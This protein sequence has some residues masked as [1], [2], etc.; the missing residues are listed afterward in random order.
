ML[1]IKCD[2][3]IGLGVK[4]IEGFEGVYFIVGNN[5][6]RFKWYY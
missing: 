3:Y 2:I 6:G 5:Y 4:K 1:Y